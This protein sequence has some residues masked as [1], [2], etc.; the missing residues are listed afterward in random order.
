MTTLDVSEI[1]DELQ[2]QFYA[3]QNDSFALDVYP[4]WLFEYYFCL[5]QH[6][7]ARSA[8]QLLYNVHVKTKA[9]N[10]RKVKDDMR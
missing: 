8:F 6:T 5:P 10:R 9:R 1:P 2:D 7:S 3:L 4:T